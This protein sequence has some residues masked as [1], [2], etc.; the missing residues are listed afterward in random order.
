[1]RWISTE[2]AWRREAYGMALYVAV[3]LDAA[4]LTLDPRGITILQLVWGTCVGLVLA[5][6]FAFALAAR[7]AGGGHRDQE[8]RELALAQL[9]GAVAIA[10]LA[11]VP[12]LLLGEP[13]ELLGVEL[14]LSAC[15]GV[16]AYGVRR[17][18]GAGPAGALVFA[19][20][21]LVIAGAIAIIK[22]ALVGH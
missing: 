12:L 3:V 4:L 15:I 11:T 9:T 18:S 10:A 21:V 2:R 5:H 7:L 6:L 14:V 19:A 20:V 16:A 17:K 22:N 1:M 8:D 13:N